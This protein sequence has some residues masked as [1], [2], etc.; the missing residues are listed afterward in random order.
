[1]AVL[2]WQ[3]KLCLWPAGQ[4]T[5][6]RRSGRSRRNAQHDQSFWPTR[7]RPGSNQ[8][9]PLASTFLPAQ[10][11]V[12]R[13]LDPPTADKQP[14]VSLSTRRSTTAE[15][16]PSPAQPSLSQVRGITWS[17]VSKQWHDRACYINGQEEGT[18]QSIGTLSAGRIAS[19]LVMLLS[20]SGV[21]RSGRRYSSL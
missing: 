18:A 4:S 20:G 3:P 15:C 5:E 19:T 1:M 11:P 17:G 6:F 13:S 8:L 9:T 14:T 12:A 2:W 21:Y 16:T 10:M 7:F